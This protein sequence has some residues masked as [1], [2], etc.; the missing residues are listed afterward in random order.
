MP[1]INLTQKQWQRLLS[2]IQHLNDSLDDNAIRTRAGEDLLDLLSADY[3]AS[4][5]WD[6]NTE[7][8]SR[9]VYLNMSSENLALYEQYYQFNDPITHKLQQFR[10]AVSVNEIMDQRDLVN[11]EFFNDFLG[12]DGLYYGIN[13]YVFDKINRNCSR[14]APL[15]HSSVMLTFL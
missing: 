5:V 9:P 14:C 12:K 6:D 13:I 8:F 11:T 3:F 2:V 1:N 10:R 7:S 15:G 4:Y